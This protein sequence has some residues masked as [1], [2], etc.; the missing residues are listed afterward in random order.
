LFQRSGSRILKHNPPASKLSTSELDSVYDL[1]FIKKPHPRYKGKKITAYEQIKNSIT[2]H[3][4]C[5]GGCSFCAIALHQGKGIQ[6]RS[7][8]SIIK[9]INQ[10]SHTKEF[11]GTVSDIGG[12]TANMYGMF[13]RLGIDQECPRE[14]CI[15]PDICPNLETSH[16]EVLDLLEQSRNVKGVK[17]SFVASGL[18][19]D[20]MTSEDEYLQELCKFHISGLLK[21]APEHKSDR[22]LKHMQKPSFKVYEDF[23]S[24]F[25]KINQ[26]LGKKQFIV[27]YII[28]GHP[29]S[30]LIDTI[31]LAV[32][33]KK[34]RIKLE[35]IQ[36]FTP[37]P[38]TIST[39]MYYT[40]KDMKGNKINIPKGRELRLQKALVQWYK[41]ENK[42]L[43][44]E[45]LK[46]AEREDLISFF[47]F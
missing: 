20:L 47:I 37:T 7:R 42:K 45:A 9:E 31:D 36:Q 40:G 15:Y 43:I 22:V 10:L 12:P 13:C 44:R 27:P 39:M 16:K 25:R 18:R 46:R 29:G 33:L 41:P 4:G 28:V 26:N 19:F 6:S 2:S 35:Q 34:N 1:K 17:N 14:S 5:F 8:N 23:V 3:R 32:Y 24:K 30:T 21:L 11:N 38:M